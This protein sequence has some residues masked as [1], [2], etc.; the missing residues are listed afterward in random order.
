MKRGGGATILANELP[1][2]RERY[3]EEKEVTHERLAKKWP[4]P[5]PTPEPLLK[6][7]TKAYLTTGEKLFLVRAAI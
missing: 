1:A 7:S 6:G 5:P 3:L 4:K 2:L